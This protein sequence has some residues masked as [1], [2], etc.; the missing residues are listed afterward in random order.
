MNQKVVVFSQ[1]DPDILARLQAQYQVVQINPKLGDVNQQISAAVQD[2]D[3]M[4][5]AGRVLNAS[6]LAT[7]KKLKIISSVSVGYDN[8]DLAYLNQQKIWLA[9]TPYVL[10]E[11]TADLAFTLLM[12]AARQVPRLD[13]WTKTGQWQRTV[14]AA[15]FGVDVFGKTLGIIGLGT[16]G[17]AIARRGF[18]GFNMNILYHNRQEKPEVAEAFNAQYCSLNTLL[19]QSD[20]VVVA[21]DLNA[22]SQALIA[23][24]ELAQMQAHAVLVNISRGSVIDEN[25]LIEALKSQQIFAAGLDVYQ[26]EPLQSSELFQ[27]DR[28]VTLPHVGSATAATRKKM[29]ELAYKNLVDGLDGRKPRTLVNPSFG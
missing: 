22:D 19:Q 21:V 8:Y 11:T 20:F 13:Q 25:A 18:H 17:A 4:I 28:V 14:G 16:I 29:A 15:Q 7:A 26:K 3:G 9:N 24:A 6:T 2:A 12:S 5:G 23:A 27:L 10:T 1:I